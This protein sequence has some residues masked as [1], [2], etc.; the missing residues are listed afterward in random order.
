MQKTK[1][2]KKASL[3][4]DIWERFTKNRVAT[5]AFAI[6]MLIILTA[7]FADVIIS[8]DRA[9]TQNIME[10]LQGASKEHWFGTDAF[11]RDVFARIIHGTRVSLII[12]AVTTVGALAI[13]CLFGASAG[14]FGGKVESVIMRLVD[15]LMCIPSSLLIMAIVAT[16]GAN[17]TNLIIAMCIGQIA[18]FT[19]IVRSV[20][21]N[22][23]DSDFIE[24]G[25]ACGAS[26]AHLIIRHILPNAIGPIIVQG[27]MN[28]SASILTAA[29]FSFIGLG[30][31]P[32]QPEWGVM[33]SEAKEYMMA[34]PTLCI[35]PGLAIVFTALSFNL[36]GDGLRDALDPRLKD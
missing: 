14:F 19:R 1:N 27:T 30:V 11:G 21:L 32:P 18:G 36:V 35:Y 29:S 12:G 16:L 22:L 33:L 13:S 2:R 4:R 31:Q 8:Y 28:I 23:R 5:I 25:R 3:T 9:T 20:V 15:I 6:L 10:R 7:I 17:V 26:N 34:N 24:A